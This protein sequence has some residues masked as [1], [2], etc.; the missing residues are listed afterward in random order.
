ME[1]R[2]YYLYIWTLIRHLNDAMVRVRDKELNT[3]SL[4][5]SQAAILAIINTLGKKATPAEIARS[6]LREPAA[7]S[8]ILKRM[9]KDGL[10]KRVKDTSYKNQINIVL[11]E[12]GGKAYKN[13]QKRGT[14]Q[15]ILSQLSDE[16]LRQLEPCIEKMLKIAVSESGSNV[17]DLFY[18]PLFK[19]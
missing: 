11:T 9:E 19:D 2:D 5:V 1:N 17:N 12:R 7:V 6:Q 3:Y 16:Q 18:R 13:A 8:S 14:A 4:T 10:V 15:R